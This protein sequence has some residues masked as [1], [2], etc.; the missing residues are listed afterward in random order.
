[1]ELSNNIP[2]M[3]NIYDSTYWNQVKN[4]EQQ[5]SNKMYNMAN[6]R[7]TGI[8][9][10]PATSDMFKKMNYTVPADNTNSPEYVKSLTGNKINRESFTHNNMTPFLRKNVTQNTNL[11]TMSPFLDNRTGSN[12][13]WQTK[14]EVPCMF[15]P[16]ANSGGNICGMKNNDDFYKSRLDFKEK[17]NNFFPI[18]Q[19][20]VG[21][22][23]NQGYESKGI[24]GF[25]QTET[26]TLARPKNLDELRSK[27]NQKQTYFNIPV[28][29][30]I[31]GTDQRGVQMP[32]VKNRPDTVYEQSEDMW[33]K[34]TGANSKESLRPAQNIRPTTRQE[35]HV[36]YQGGVSLSDA[37]AGIRDDYGKSKVIVY[38]NERATTENKPVVSNV[39]SIVKAIVSPVVDALKYTMKE[40][41]V[42]SER[43]VGNPSIQIPE[44]ATTYDP[45]NH[46]MKTTVKETTIHDSEMINL[47]GNKETYS[48]ITDQAKTT[49][50]E[51]LIH[52]SVYTNVKGT[53]GGYTKADDEAK[54]TIRE[55]VKAVDTVRNIGGVTY[56]VSV[57][58]PEIVA[59]TT[60][61]ET[62]LVAKSP[63]G[64]LGGMLEGL[65][66]GYINKE[67][68][69]KNTHKQFLSD[70]NE[71]GIAGA[72]NEHR[73]RDRTAEENAEIDDTRERIMIAAG[74]TPNP[75][76]MNIN[77]DSADVEMTTRKP[78]ENSAAARENGN[79]GMIYQSSP[80]I[81]ECGITKMPQ[82]SNAYSNRLDS[83]LLEPVN[84]NDLMKTQR[85]NP[86]K[87]GCKL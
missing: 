15:K 49:V 45:D 48:T 10:M 61:K 64:F 53:D 25:H 27:I 81:D 56:S 52:D 38:N 4:D 5:R 18:E 44:K 37:N 42:E 72:I 11:D 46:I 50:K 79:V 31:K 28:K 75:G 8:V 54:T 9:S 82:K 68:D 39:T 78:F 86:I 63:Y 24:G 30:H 70:T 35:S 55:T 62:T 80:T 26:N 85:I 76:N 87:S 21:P 73:Q 29:G 36:D 74:H 83:D 43:G 67:I 12:Q 22:G 84:N 13:F 23:L 2:S 69:L 60:V 16:Q 32:L 58:D 34:T 65:F 77:R 3:K 41:T 14:K 33:I 6:A 57:Y 47:T 17:A 66:G 40:Y 7:N 71:Y 19:V 59:R 1:M 20:K 51:T